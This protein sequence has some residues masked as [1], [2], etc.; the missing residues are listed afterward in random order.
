MRSVQN[1]L[2]FAILLCSLTGIVSAD[3]TQSMSPITGKVFVTNVT[4]DPAVFFS[5]DKGTVTY[6]VM[7]SNTNTSVMLNHG[8][9]YDEKIRLLSGT[10]DYSNTLG[11]LQTRAFA[12]SIGAD[13]LEGDY[14]P[15]FTLSFYDSNLYY[16]SLLQVDNT[17]L[18]ITVVDMPDAF[19]KGK[20]KTVYLQVANPRKNNVRN[21]ILEVAGSGITVSPQRSYIG[22]LAAGTKM[23]VNITITPEQET[24]LLLTV[25]YDNGDNPHRKSMEFP[26]AFGIDKKQAEPVVSNIQVK[27]EAGIYHVTGDVNNAGL[28]TA[29]TVKV[30]S[31]SPAEPQDPYR[32]YVVGALKP[33]DFGSFEITFTAV[34]GN[35]SIPIELSYKDDDGNV[36]TSIQDVKITSSAV[37]ASA[38]SGSFN[39]LPVAAVIVLVLIF[40]GAWVYYLRRNKK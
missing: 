17:P 7:N 18:E 14:Y 5:G 38:E 35:T 30:T 3:L 8:S 34:P 10:Y 13:A 40:V 37:S 21:V 31:L 4:F 26:V 19:T 2:I 28:E 23:P 16:K 33:D 1:I 12:F 25:T 15:T 39:M 36:Y 20:K 9:F 6:T 29:N 27:T 24:T 11:P 22:D 32:S